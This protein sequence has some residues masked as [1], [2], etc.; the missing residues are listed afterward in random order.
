MP[1]DR[2]FPI[3]RSCNKLRTMNDTPALVT[4]VSAEF[5]YARG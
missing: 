3:G 4:A 2:I 1:V 5:H